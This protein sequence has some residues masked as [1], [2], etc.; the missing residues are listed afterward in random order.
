MFK[1]I[2]ANRNRAPLRLLP[3]ARNIPGASPQSGDGGSAPEHRK[4]KA[5]RPKGERS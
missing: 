1:G 5:Q 4:D 3:L 2:P